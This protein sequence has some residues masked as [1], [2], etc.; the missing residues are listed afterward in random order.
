MQKS[1]TN[2]PSVMRRP[3]NLWLGV[4]LLLGGLAGHVRAAQAIGGSYVA[5][6]DHLFGFALLTV[7][8]TVLFVAVGLKF[9]RGRHDIT[10]LCVGV[11]QAAIGVFVY[12]ERF[13]VHG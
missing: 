11:M 13:S 5:Y 3:L 9:W 1:G 12:I 2:A 10:L 8:S 6:R 7:V 4:G